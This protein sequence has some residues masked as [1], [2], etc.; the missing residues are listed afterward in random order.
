MIGRLKNVYSQKSGIKVSPGIIESNRSMNKNIIFFINYFSVSDSNELIIPG[1]IRHYYI[2][3]TF[4]YLYDHKY[5]NIFKIIF[6][7]SSMS[8]L[9]SWR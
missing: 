9:W 7:R 8:T 6:I 1:K 2:F 4:Y 5:I 3:I